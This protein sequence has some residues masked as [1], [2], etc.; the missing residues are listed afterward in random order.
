MG[1]LTRI[2]SGLR[3]MGVSGRCAFSG[4]RGGGT[5]VS[6]TTAK[7]ISREMSKSPYRLL[8]KRQGT[9]QDL[10]SQD[11]D[12]QDLDSQDLDSAGRPQIRASVGDFGP[13]LSVNRV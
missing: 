1:A 13:G 9:R 5:T 8:T 3:S 11:L 6:S 7:G 10:D 2:Q 12:S 4:W